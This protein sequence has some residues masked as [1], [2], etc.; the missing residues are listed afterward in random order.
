MPGGGRFTLAKNNLS[1]AHRN[2]CYW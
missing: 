2:V 1:P